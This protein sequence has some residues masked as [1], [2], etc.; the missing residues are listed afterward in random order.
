[1]TMLCALALLGLLG[2]TGDQHNGYVQLKDSRFSLH[3]E[4]FYPMAIN[5]ILDLQWKGD[6]CWSSSTFDYQPGG[7]FRFN[8]PKGARQQ[9]KAEFDLI[10][11]M[12]FNTVRVVGMTSN[13]VLDTL[14]HELVHPSRYDRGQDTIYRFTGQHLARYLDAV[15]DMVDVAD[16]AGLHVIILLKLVPDQPLFEQHALQL[17]ERL[18]DKRQVLAYDLFN[19]PLYFD[20]PHHRPKEKVH[21]V[22]KGW[23]NAIRKQAP[24]QL[25]TIGLVG[26]PEVFSWDP[27]ILDVD[28]ISFHPYEYEPEQVRNEIRWYGEHVDKPW[29]I[30]ETAI[31]ADN[32]S[33]PYAE[34]LAFAR[35]TLAQTVA[36]G[37]MGYSWWQFKDVKWGQFHADYMGVMNREG[38]TDAGPGLPKVEGTIKPTADAFREFDPEADH[39]SCAELPNYRNFSAFRTAKLYGKLLD[40]DRKPINGGIVLGWNE[41]WTTSYYTIS[42]EDGSFELYG[43][44]RFHHWMVSATR[45][46]VQRGDCQPGAFITGHDGVASF[47]LGDFTLNRL[48]LDE[49]GSR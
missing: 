11:G 5:Y 16:E 18:K 9:L 14:A 23:R 8:S 43:D 38:W 15:A 25:V 26:V 34:Q 33:V 13:L 36:C 35:K 29:I 21:Q 46:G 27:N 47:Y 1:M 12:G 28:F 44:F 4:P 32:D 20:K 40:Q 6:S 30:G 19:E 31:P 24:D 49:S 41:D 10:R 3:G 45:H 48:A 2:C 17:V 37:G 39:G 22:V 42:K 7:K